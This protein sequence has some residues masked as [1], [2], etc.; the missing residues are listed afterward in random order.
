MEYLSLFFSCG[1]P[2]M[3]IV[4]GIMVGTFVQNAHLRRLAEMERQLLTIPLTDIKTVPPGVDA[5]DARMVVGSVV[6]ATDYFRTFAAT[7]R[8]LI[9][10]EIHFYERLLQ[11]ARRE[12]I[13]RMMQQAQNAGAT[14]VINLRIETS[15]I[16]GMAKN[17]AP[18][19]EVVAYGTAV[20]PT[21]SG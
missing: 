17:P 21:K 12:A 5:G 1:L 14:A 7:L 6:L 2:V 18:M 13:C 11:R 4:I 16:G 19:C 3:L 15:N 8:K 20:L 9:G 10:G